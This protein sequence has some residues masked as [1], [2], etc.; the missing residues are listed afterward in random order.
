VTWDYE[1]ID[2]IY[3]LSEEERKYHVGIVQ[4]LKNLLY[5]EILMTFDVNTK[6]VMDGERVFIAWD[7]NGVNVKCLPCMFEGVYDLDVT[8]LFKDLS[9]K[10][11]LGKF[12]FAS[13]MTTSIQ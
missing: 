6:C 1:G 9:Y 5:K 2:A 4:L 3:L 10:D 7:H 11:I 13:H 8:N 12:M